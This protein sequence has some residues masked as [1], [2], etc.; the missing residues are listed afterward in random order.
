MSEDV[1]DDV[2]VLR[3]ASLPAACGVAPFEAV[4][5]ALAPGELAVVTVESEE[6][7]GCLADLCEGLAHP[8]SGSVSFSGSE[9]RELSALRACAARGRIGRVFAGEGWISHLDV[10]ENVT[11]AQR[12]HT[13][14]PEPEILEEASR[15][16]RLAGLADVPAVRPD[17]LA[18]E[19]LQRYQWVRAF[20]GG[21]ALV[22]L[23][24]PDAG[25]TPGAV[26]GLYALV[27][28]AVE[29]RATVLWLRL[30]D[31]P[32]P[33]PDGCRARCFTMQQGRLVADR[34]DV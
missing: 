8:A 19:D 14:R 7:A 26:D 11:L 5:L 30:A 29:R 24:R 32:R 9:W 31:D 28:A 23:E 21:P 34:E 18:E 12:H 2:L 20:L 13:S 1:Q 25:L 33:A 22:L 4:T 17:K 27:T 15:L 10:S 6:Q 3:A 16:A